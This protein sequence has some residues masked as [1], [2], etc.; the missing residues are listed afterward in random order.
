MSGSSLAKRYARGVI[1]S[2]ASEEEYTTIKDELEQFDLLLSKNRDFYSG[3]VTP[4]LARDQKRELLEV[5]RGKGGFSDKTMNF[6]MTLLEENRFSWLR[7]ILD[8]MDALW[9]VNRGIEKLRVTSAVPLDEDLASRLRARLEK[10]F[11][12]PVQLEMDTNPDLIAGIRIQRGSVAY[13]LS[14]A[15]NLRKLYQR[16]VGGEPGSGSSLP[17]SQGSQQE[18]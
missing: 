16:I 15:G 10:A 5:I 11:E 3:L 12:G 13:D 2:V 6:L 14:I 9:L 1:K 7:E 8:M 18:Y 17:E 4:L